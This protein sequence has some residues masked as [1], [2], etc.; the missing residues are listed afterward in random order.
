VPDD[1]EERESPS[2]LRIGGS[3]SMAYM[4]A[5]QFDKSKNH[6]GE[7]CETPQFKAKSKEIVYN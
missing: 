2:K 4:V 7:K 5:P 1:L 6:L 3:K